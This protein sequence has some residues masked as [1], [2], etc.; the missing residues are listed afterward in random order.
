MDTITATGPTALRTFGFPDADSDIL[1]AAPGVRPYA[2]GDL[3]YAGTTAQLAR[4]ADVAVGQVLVSGGVGVVPAWS[5]SPTL[6]TVTVSGSVISGVI[7]SGA[8]AI[9]LANNS[10]IYW[11]N[12]AN[13]ADLRGLFVAGD[14]NAY[15]DRS[16]VGG[17]DNTYDIGLVATRWRTGYFGTALAVGTNPATAGAVRLPNATW[18]AAR[19]AANT[20]DVNLI[21]LDASN[22]PS[23]QGGASRGAGAVTSLTV[24]NGIVTAI[25]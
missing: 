2:I 7:P 16:L 15:T 1:T 11:R 23:I 20:G 8:G 3:I 4:L 22:N 21:S 13:N 10:G 12:A 6:T 19:N 9:R 14:N 5:A 24:V 18:I 17:T 25:S